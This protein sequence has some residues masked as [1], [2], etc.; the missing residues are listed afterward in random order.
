MIFSSLY[1]IFTNKYF[2]H[3]S[4]SRSPHPF[5]V[6]LRTIPYRQ[7]RDFFLYT[8]VVVNTNWIFI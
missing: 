8:I 6:R 5:R 7:L 3:F 1:I 4:P 2:P